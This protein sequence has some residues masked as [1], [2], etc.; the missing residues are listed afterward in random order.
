MPIPKAECDARNLP[1]TQAF[2]D[3]VTCTP[4]AP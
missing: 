1:T 3:V 2:P 4:L